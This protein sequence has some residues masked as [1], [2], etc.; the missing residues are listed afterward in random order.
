M[1]MSFKVKPITK[2]ILIIS[3]LFL[4]GVGAALALSPQERAAFDAIRWQKAQEIAATNPYLDS[5]GDGLTDEFEWIFGTDLNNSDSDGDG[6]S[7]FIEIDNAYDPLS[8]STQ[9][10]PQKIEIDL[11]NQRLFYLVNG[12]R[13][14]E[15]MVSS[16][17]PSMPTPTGNFQIRNKAKLAWSKNYGLYMPYWLGIVGGI[18]IHQLPYWPN[19]YRE[20]ADHLG[21]PVSHGC[22]R[23]GIIPAAYLFER[24]EVGTPV[25]IY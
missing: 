21:Q 20:G 23:L 25:E 24:V 8:S 18:G 14:R 6:H 12:V 15:F 19:G 3:L 11:K 22:I 13:W 2:A 5:D 4:V 16:G 10:F 7:D 9:K 1:I 17:K